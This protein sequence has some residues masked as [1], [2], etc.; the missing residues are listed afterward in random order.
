MAIVEKKEKAQLVHLNSW[1]T[2]G[3]CG[4]IFGSIAIMDLFRIDAKHLSIEVKASGCHSMQGTRR[5]KVSQNIVM[6]S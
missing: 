6:S 4:E 2:V 1:S 3:K 5:S